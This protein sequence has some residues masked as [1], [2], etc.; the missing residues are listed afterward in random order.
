[1]IRWRK[2][3]FGES[4]ESFDYIKLTY[5]AVGID[6]SFL[7]IFSVPIEIIHNNLFKEE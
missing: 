3:Q 4:K 2:I 1:M 5:S 7:A 6:K